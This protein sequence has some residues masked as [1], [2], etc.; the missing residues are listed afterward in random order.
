MRGYVANH[1][2]ISVWHG[3]NSTN[4]IDRRRALP[5]AEQ[6]GKLLPNAQAL[7]SLVVAHKP[8][9]SLP[10]APQQHRYRPIISVQV[11]T[12]ITSPSSIATSRK[13]CEL[14]NPQ[15]SEFIRS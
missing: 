2:S 5:P 12:A 9:Q 11:N 4:Q 14:T 8:R 7:L 1:L 10:E 6:T 15:T 3:I 13:V